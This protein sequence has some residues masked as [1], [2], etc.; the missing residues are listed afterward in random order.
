MSAGPAVIRFDTLEPSWA[1]KRATEPGFHR[2]LVSWLGGQDGTVNFNPGQAAQSRRAAMGFM[3]MPR[4]NRQAGVHVHSVAEI[5][6][7]LKGEI[8]GFDHTGVPH[9]AGPFDCIHIP[10]GVPHGV[11][12]VGGEDLHLVWVHDAIERLGVSQ[13]L[14][15]AAPDATTERIRIVSVPDGGFAASGGGPAGRRVGY[16]GDGA[17]EVPNAGIRLGLHSLPSGAAGRFE[18]GGE[19]GGEVGASILL[20][21]GGV[22]VVRLADRTET[23]GYLDAV[24]LPPGT[25]ATIWNSRDAPVRLLRLDER[26][27]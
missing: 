13:Y 10:A 25:G 15:A 8:E 7:I 17:G 2:W 14:D 3:A 5:Y 21:V 1:V 23:L 6:V 26:P 24:H 11:R 4:G 22:A 16:V 12:T 18:A 27:D 19:S 20:N 9:R